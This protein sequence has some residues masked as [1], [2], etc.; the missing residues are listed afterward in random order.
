MSDFSAQF[1]LL[2]KDMEISST[3]KRKANWKV[4]HKIWIDYTMLEFGSNLI[5]FYKI[6][7]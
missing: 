3:K 7:V 6:D 5:Q 1:S 2:E 4:G